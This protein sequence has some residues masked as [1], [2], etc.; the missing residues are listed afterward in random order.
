[1]NKKWT[2]YPK[3]NP[4]ILRI[5]EDDVSDDWYDELEAKPKSALLGKVLCCCASIAIAQAVIEKLYQNHKA[6][7]EARLLLE[8]G[9]D[10][11]NSPTEERFSKITKFLF[12]DVQNWLE[13]DPREVTWAAL[14][15]LTSSVGNYEAGYE[16]SCLTD[17]AD[18][19]NINS[20]EVSKEAILKYAK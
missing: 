4:E 10:W 2:W 15:V 5:F 18:D 19:A 16:L 20:V 14:R 7:E 8:L 3:K 9:R 12:E 11:I 6:Y 13:D 17:Y 1:M